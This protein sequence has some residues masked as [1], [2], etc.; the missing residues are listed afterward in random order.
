MTGDDD[1]IFMGAIAIGGF[2]L[3]NPA[4]IAGLVSAVGGNLAVGQLRTD[5]G[6]LGDPTKKV[7]WWSPGIKGLEF[8]GDLIY[9]WSQ[10]EAYTRRVF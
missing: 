4:V 7:S 10:Q 3:S 1:L 2:L 6:S 8:V 5:I 9:G